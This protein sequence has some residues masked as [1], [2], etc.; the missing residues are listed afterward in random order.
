[1]I[2]IDKSFF[3]NP[4]TEYLKWLYNKI[5][6]QWAYRGQ[7][8]R[9]GY[10]TTLIN[11]TFGHYNWVN[12]NTVLHNVSVG[13][14]TYFSKNSEIAEASIGKFCSIGPNVKIAPG[15]HPTHTIVSTHPAIYSNPPYCQKNFSTDDKHKPERH[16]TI[17]NDVW[18]GANAVIGDGITIENGAII[19]ANSLVVKNVDAYSIVSG[20]PAK[21][22]RYRFSDQEIAVLQATRWWDNDIEWLEKNAHF[23]WNISDFMAEFSKTEQK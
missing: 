9:I 7:Y 16:V 6:Y 1:M 22:V 4:I 12:D 19:A 11:V 14:F 20:V 3:R 10:K 5:S 23:L 21:H 13:H 18:V 8:L 17:G 15:K 2:L